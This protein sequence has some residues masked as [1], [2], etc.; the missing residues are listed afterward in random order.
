MKE[1]TDNVYTFVVSGSDYRRLKIY[2]LGTANDKLSKAIVSPA[3]KMVNTNFTDA[4]LTA[5]STP[6]KAIHMTELQNIALVG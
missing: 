5:G 1:T 3:V 4:V 6:I 2:V